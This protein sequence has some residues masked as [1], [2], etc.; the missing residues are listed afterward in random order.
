M[1]KI[2]GGKVDLKPCYNMALINSATSEKKK[3]F[4][5]GSMDTRV[6]HNGGGHSFKKQTSK[7]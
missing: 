1:T 7:Q 4:A 3:H 5:E 2:S 6:E